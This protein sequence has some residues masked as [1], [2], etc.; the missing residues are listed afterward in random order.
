MNSEFR[1]AFGQLNARFDELSTRLNEY[2][3]KIENVLVRVEKC[4]TRVQDLSAE[5]D[6][7]VKQTTGEIR[8]LRESLTAVQTPKGTH[9]TA[10]QKLDKLNSSIKI[11]SPEL[12]FPADK[13]NKVSS[14]ASFM[15][16][17]ELMSGPIPAF[18]LTV[19]RAEFIN[20]KMEN[21]TEKNFL[22]VQCHSPASAMQLKKELQ[23]CIS[24][25]KGPKKDGAFPRFNL[26]YADREL[27]GEHRRLT[28]MLM[29]L[30]KEA[31]FDRFRLFPVMMD[32]N[33]VGIGFSFAKKCE[34][35][36]LYFNDAHKQCLSYSSTTDESVLAL[37]R[38]LSTLVPQFFDEAKNL[39]KRGKHPDS[40]KRVRTSENESDS[41]EDAPGHGKKKYA[42]VVQGGR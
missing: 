27:R 36:F 19:A 1:E 12:F 21:G 26:D 34:G 14:K 23:S 15:E 5:H 35:K 17:V 25:L 7:H 6:R 10:A 31:A 29:G 18:K 30:K 4:E 41:A 13:R 40:D 16:I 11:T 33:S 2:N 39:I 20:T 8:K 32:T 42:S 22:C 38:Y 9:M 24:Q 3:E 37:G 28:K